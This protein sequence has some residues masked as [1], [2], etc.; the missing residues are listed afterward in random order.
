MFIPAIQK[1]DRLLHYDIPFIILHNCPFR[2]ENSR[3]FFIEHLPITCVDERKMF[4]V[5]N[6]NLLGI[7]WI[8]QISTYWLCETEPDHNNETINCLTL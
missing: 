3:V 6:K 2:I 1:K 8:S 7:S 5:L 4:Y